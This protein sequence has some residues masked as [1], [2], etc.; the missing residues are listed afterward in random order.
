MRVRA[1]GASGI[2]RIAQCEHMGITAYSQVEHNPFILESSI[3]PYTHV[4][5][6]PSPARA[7]GPRESG[8]GDSQSTLD[9]LIVSAEEVGEFILLIYI[10]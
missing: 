2:A 5:H 8:L 7:P 6:I 3:F 4:E 9:S 10:I 1:R